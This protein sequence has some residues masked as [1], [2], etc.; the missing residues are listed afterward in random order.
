MFRGAIRL[1]LAIIFSPKETWKELS[2]TKDGDKFFERN[3]LFPIFI[4]IALASLIGGYLHADQHLL[5]NAV[6]NMII[7]VIEISASL[8]ISS[9]LLN[10]YLG[11]IS[12]KMKDISKSRQFMA[13]ASALNYVLYI[14]VAL[15]DDLFFLWMFSIYA[16]YLVYIGSLEFIKLSEEKRSQF[17]VIA[18][19]LV[20][21]VPFIIKNV[22]GHIIIKA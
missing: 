18:S 1:L 12:L 16:A 21:F 11:S 13:Y 7:S 19:L 17:V 15:L 10:E 5:Q 8:I 4:L 20:L 2:I 14:L 9:Y 22:L 3:Y 6:K